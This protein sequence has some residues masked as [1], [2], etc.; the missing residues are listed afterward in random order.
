MGQRQNPTTDGKANGG[1]DSGS[2][3]PQY[4]VR[5]T[6]KFANSLQL[7]QSVQS[8]T[9]R[10]VCTTKENILPFGPLTPGPNYSSDLILFAAFPCQL[11]T[12]KN[13]IKEMQNIP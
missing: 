13:T 10:S 7:V 3:R 12:F 11:Y 9:V 4:T 5:K 2:Q 6:D 1:F 8:Q